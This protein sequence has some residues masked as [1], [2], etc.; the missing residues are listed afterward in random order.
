MLQ[1]R[2]IQC[3]CH[4]GLAGPLVPFVLALCPSTAVRPER[5]VSRLPALLV[6]YV[7]QGSQVVVEGAVEVVGVVAAVGV[8]MG[9][10]VATLVL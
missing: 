2:E 5:R 3:V 8:V 1:E 7:A 4:P 6:L 10:R 9:V